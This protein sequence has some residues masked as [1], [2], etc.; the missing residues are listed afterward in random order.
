MQ[1]SNWFGYLSV[2]VDAD[3]VL[4]MVDDVA[5]PLNPLVAPVEQEELE[6]TSLDMNVS[7]RLCEE[8]LSK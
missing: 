3:E 4:I 5:T 7:Q 8:E 1:V 2:F 6:E